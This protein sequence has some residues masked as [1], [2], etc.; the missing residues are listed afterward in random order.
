M[1]SNKSNNNNNK[2]TSN[3]TNKLNSVSANNSSTI[4]N[5]ILEKSLLMPML[6]IKNIIQGT[7]NTLIA[8]IILLIIV[9]FI[10]IV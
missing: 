5:N 3:K 10:F 9:S 6:Y 1:N 4:E 8:W 7:T 2:L